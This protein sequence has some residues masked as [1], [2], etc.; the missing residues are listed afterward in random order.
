MAAAK[1]AAP[2]LE[3]ERQRIGTEFGERRWS[4]V[5]EVSFERQSPSS[6]SSVVTIRYDDRQ[7]L[8]SRGVDMYPCRASGGG[9]APE[10]FTEP[11]HYAEPPPGWSPWE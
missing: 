5:V 2:R 8:L 9:Y 3:A 4:S 10:P 7:G 11:R 1:S 6:P